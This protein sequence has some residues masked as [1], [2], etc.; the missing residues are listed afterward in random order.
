M[1]NPGQN[2]EVTEAP[3]R[4]EQAKAKFNASEAAAKV[5]IGKSQSL[6]TLVLVSVTASVLI[7]SY[8]LIVGLFMAHRKHAD[9]VSDAAM[10]AAKELSDVTVQH[11]STG[12]VSLCRWH[13]KGTLFSDLASEQTRS[14]ES[15]RRT[16]RKLEQIG[17][18]CK[19]KQFLY[20][21]AQDKK[22]FKQI[23][24]DLRSRLEIAIKPP[25]KP[26]APAAPQA[27]ERAGKGAIYKSVQSLIASRYGM[28]DPSPL[29]LSIQLGCTKD[30][31]D[32][33]KKQVVFVKPEAFASAPAGQAPNMVLISYTE[34]DKSKSGSTRAKRL[35]AC[36]YIAPAEDTNWPTA[37]VLT[38]PNGVP[39]FATRL[40]DYLQ[41]KTWMQ[42][43]IWQQAV[44]GD[45][46]GPGHLTPPVEP[47]LPEMTPADA[48][49]TEL[50]HWL[51]YTGDGIDPGRVSSML[52]E[53]WTTEPSATIE[54]TDVDDRSF[55]TNDDQVNSCIVTE[56]GAREHALIYNNK[57]GEAGQAALAHAFLV[58]GALNSSLITKP[59]IPENAFPLYIDTAGRCTIIGQAVFDQK[60]IHDFFADLLAT[61]L[62][63][64]ETLATVNRVSQRS[65]QE[66]TRLEIKMRR[67]RD[68]LASLNLRNNRLIAEIQTTRNAN[69]P[70]KDLVLE[71]RIT[72]D[73]I[74]ELNSLFDTDTTQV[75]Q[76]QTV[77]RLCLTAQYNAK[78]AQLNTFDLNAQK[79]RFCRD[80]L[81]RID[82][83]GYLMGGNLAF[84]PVVKAL[85]D[86][87]LAKYLDTEETAN[88]TTQS[89]IANAVAASE[90]SDANQS[91]WF[92]KSLAL[93][94]HPDE[95]FPDKST[96]LGAK[97]SQLLANRYAP[98]RCSPR[99][100]VVDSRHIMPEKGVHSNYIQEFT[101]YPFGNI[102]IPQS[103]L[104]YYCQTAAKTG[105]S[106]KI[107]WS[108]LARD[109]VAIRAQN[110]EKA[111]S[112][113]QV[114]QPVPAPN[115]SWYGNTFNGSVAPR[116]AAEFQVRTP[117]PITNE[118]E[119]SY[120]QNIQNGQRNSLIPLVTPDML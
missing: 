6:F 4:D 66:I 59:A 23:E 39:S 22:A 99:M 20:L 28:I 98:Q 7:A 50:Y 32:T 96:K 41:E 83:R 91:P 53:A 77:Q 57:E 49:A 101:K 45:V 104:I 29:A 76:Y 58:N 103:Q 115:S 54:K 35:A 87:D 116:L 114:G 118:F 26:S 10:E 82:Q 25:D 72:S 120:L 3:G 75:N 88:D 93:V 56:N 11:P 92:A 18:T 2:T 108:V 21:V 70:T 68:E 69:K 55:G 85:L 60:L 109:F 74:D 37:F 78:R 51:K 8:V 90:A 52:K 89:S 31:I 27:V 86:E 42:K 14:L 97:W 46:P 67:E 64:R 94:G 19:I 47:M 44:G 119:D 48:L 81:L 43:G 73:Q 16:Y 100:L 30:P 110:N 9:T 5:G 12:I 61:N 62:A 80:G 36:V 65:S 102:A 33:N 107:G 63:A 1:E 105:D 79:L 38:F 17:Y 84:R 117:L 15:V 113:S 111:N 112:Y 34:P 40:A 13:K 95:L 71:Q 106:P 24:F